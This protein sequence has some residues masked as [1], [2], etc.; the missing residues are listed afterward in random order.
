MSYE[1]KINGHTN[2][3]HNA[4]VQEVFAK[5]VEELKAMDPQGS[6]SGSGYTWDSEGPK[7]ELKA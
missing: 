7:V 5:A 6:V 3:P 1:I 2:K 4:K